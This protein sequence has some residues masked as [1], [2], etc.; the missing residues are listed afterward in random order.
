VTALAG[1]LHLLALVL[2]V[3]GVQKLLAPS[4]PAAAM[5]DARLPLPARGR[6]VTGIVLGVVELAT[7]VA[8]LAVPHRLAAAWL[9]VFYLALAGFVLLLRS[10]DADAGCGCFGAASTPP[11]T[12]HLVLNGVAAATAFGI[13]VAGV[14]DIVDVVDDGILTAAAYVVLLAVGA[15]V[16]LVAPALTAEVDRLVRG[17][18]PDPPVRTFGSVS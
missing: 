10:R 1:P 2:V 8:A 14:P 9:G 7:G 13:A 5:A 15:A 11:G 6:P 4:A 3:S 17:E 16:L 12:A 18:H